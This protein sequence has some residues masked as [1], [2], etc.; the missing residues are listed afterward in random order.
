MTVF[1]KGQPVGEDK[2]R[3]KSSLQ[4]G[5]TPTFNKFILM[6]GSG[7]TSSSTVVINKSSSIALVLWPCLG[8]GAEMTFGFSSASNSISFASIRS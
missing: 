6:I 1:N 8:I 7:V 5:K 2:Q 3:W 4:P